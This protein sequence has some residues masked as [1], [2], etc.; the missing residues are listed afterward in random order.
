MSE[1]LLQSIQHGRNLVVPH[2]TRENLAGFGAVPSDCHENVRRWCLIHA[3]HRPLRGWAITSGFVYDKHSV[4]DC[5]GVR[6]IDITPMT[7][8]PHTEFLTFSGAQAE[9]EALPNQEFVL[10]MAPRFID[11]IEYIPESNTDTT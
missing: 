8:R 1:Q 6:I 7:D 2:A 9:F 4:V 3:D 11:F 10:G 5:G